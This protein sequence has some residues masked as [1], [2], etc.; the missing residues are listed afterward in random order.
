MFPSIDRACLLRSD[1]DGIRKVGRSNIYSAPLRHADF[2]KFIQNNGIFQEGMLCP[3]VA[4]RCR[5]N[6]ASND[7]ILKDVSRLKRWNHDV[8]LFGIGVSGG[9][10]NGDRTLFCDSL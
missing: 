2:N 10:A 9:A 1:I 7:F 8:L 5:V 3:E 6:K 4:R